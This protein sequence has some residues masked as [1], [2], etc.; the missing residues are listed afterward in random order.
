MS[1]AKTPSIFATP[2][3]DKFGNI[4]FRQEEF[5]HN[6]V[7][8]DFGW[9][10]WDI[11]DEPFGPFVHEEQAKVAVRLYTERLTKGEIKPQKKTLI[12]PKAGQ[13]WN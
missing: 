8:Y 11:D 7:H 2:T 10:F 6:N 9:Y 3:S 4:F 13:P 5:L 12:V 1:I